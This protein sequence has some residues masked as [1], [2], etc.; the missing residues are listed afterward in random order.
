MKKKNI[1]NLLLI[2]LGFLCGVF[3]GVMLVTVA[4]EGM[5]DAEF[6]LWFGTVLI[7]LGIAVFFQT[8]IHEG[9]HLV[10]GLI[11]GYQ[12]T[13]FRIGSLQLSRRGGKLRF[14]RF[15]VAG[16][17]G[18][19]LMT[20]PEAENGEI[21]VTMYNL[22]GSLMNLLFSLVCLLIWLVLDHTTFSAIFLILFAAFGIMFALMNGIPMRL[23]TVDND[24]YNAFALRK[25]SNARDAFALQLRVNARIAKG[26]RIR[27]LPESWFEQPAD[28]DMKNAMIAAKGLLLCNRMVDEHRYAQAGELAAH[29]LEIPTGFAGIHRN[30]LICERLCCLLLTEDTPEKARVLYTKELV[31]FF[32]AMKNSPS[33]IRTQY[34]YA[35]LAE[36]DTKKVEKFRKQFEKIE[37]TYPYPNDMLADREMMDAALARKEEMIKNGKK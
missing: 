35:L 36:N 32:K 27:E 3:G 29:Y 7:L 9:G 14:S 17:G 34:I 15:S 2:V 30:M 16:T 10:F 1:T 8:I 20:P 31:A 22:G 13:S 12:F 24:G 19:C 18:Q 28:A 25:D 37:K 11:S 23:G 6:F 21:P 4:P 5:S 33:V 26:Q